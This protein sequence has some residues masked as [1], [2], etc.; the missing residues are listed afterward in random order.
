MRLPFFAEVS[1]D[2]HVTA[3][4][5]QPPPTM[6]NCF[7]RI[8]LVA[9]CSAASVSMAHAEEAGLLILL[10]AGD[11]EPTVWDGS[12]TVS[13]G[14]VMELTGWR[15]EQTDRIMKGGAWKCSTRNEAVKGRTNNP[16]KMGKANRLRGPMA[17]N[18]IVARLME[19]DG[20]SE[21]S[22]TTEQGAF[23]FKLAD[24]AYGVRKEMLDGR[25]IVQRTAS[26]R[27]LSTERTDDDFPA[28]AVDAK[29]RVFVTWQSF[30]PGIDRD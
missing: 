29:N 9:F 30:T 5:L 12:L 27:R 24:L 19:V 28:M 6:K 23:S 16:K 14:K 26:G 2:L 15:F 13:S 3:L 22:I 20:A 1:Q 25:V 10:G 17:D 18:G 11:S 8:C 4:S 7:L 21:V